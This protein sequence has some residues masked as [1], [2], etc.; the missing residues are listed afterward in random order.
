MQVMTVLEFT[1]AFVVKC[2]IR[3]SLLES[4]INA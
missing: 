2:D 4:N 1:T 3:S